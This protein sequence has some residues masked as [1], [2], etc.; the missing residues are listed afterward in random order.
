M[1]KMI[2]IKED[3]WV[4]ESNIASIVRVDPEDDNKP[5]DYK[6]F[7]NGRLGS[8]YYIGEDDCPE[9]RDNVWELLHPKWRD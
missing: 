8:F 2:R 5:Y 9:C 3:V 1:S 7:M 6:V 4:N